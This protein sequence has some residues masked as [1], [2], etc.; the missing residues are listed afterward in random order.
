MARCRRASKHLHQIWHQRVKRKQC[1]GP[2]ALL[3]GDSE[4]MGYGRGL[5]REVRR[6]PPLAAKRASIRSCS[7]CQNGHVPRLVRL[8]TLDRDFS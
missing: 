3:Q 1:F 7:T 6:M 8:F 5:G 2:L 4:G